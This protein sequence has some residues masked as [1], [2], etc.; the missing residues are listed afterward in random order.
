MNSIKSDNYYYHPRTTTEKSATTEEKPDD[1]TV[2]D[3]IEVEVKMWD[4]HI[5]RLEA[6]LSFLIRS[7]DDPNL[8]LLYQYEKKVATLKR[9]INDAIEQRHM[10]RGRDTN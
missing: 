9:E 4:D 8:D 6:K 7:Y 10:I 2:V 5:E 1:L 3:E